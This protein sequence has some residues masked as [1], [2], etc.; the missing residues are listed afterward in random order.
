MDANTPAR[1][2]GARLAL[3][4]GV[5]ASAEAIRLLWGPGFDTQLLGVRIRSNDPVHAAVLA[6]LTFGVFALLRRPRH[7]RAID[8]AAWTARLR[9]ASPLLLI[10]AGA[11]LVRGWALGFG[12]P[13]LMCR[14]DE[15]AVASIAG[16]L[17]AET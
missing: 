6:A 5:L 9:A 4:A 1:R 2:V 7:A 10:L 3:L 15:E 12:L 14:P 8:R 17:Y 16:S 11:A 13:H